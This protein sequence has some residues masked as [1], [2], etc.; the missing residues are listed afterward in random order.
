MRATNESVWRCRTVW[1]THSFPHARTHTHTPRFTLPG[2]L[3]RSWIRL[4][5]PFSSTSRLGSSKSTSPAARACDS[6]LTCKCLRG[7]ARLRLIKPPHHPSVSALH[8]SATDDDVCDRLNLEPPSLPPKEPPSL[9]AAYVINVPQ[10][11]NTFP[12]PCLPACLPIAS[13]RTI[14]ECWPDERQ[15]EAL[16]V[17]NSNQRPLSQRG[18]EWLLLDREGQFGRTVRQHG[19]TRCAQL[20]HVFTKEQRERC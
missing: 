7:L 20:W 12:H 15:L 13:S 18:S 8:L 11:S 3:K 10:V 16:R 2:D 19:W 14:W 17:I 6:A 1:L 5:C 9:A 4:G